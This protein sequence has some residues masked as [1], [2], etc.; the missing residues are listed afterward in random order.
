MSKSM[1]GSELICLA[2]DNCYIC[3]Q[4]CV[5]KLAIKINF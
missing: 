5:I 3:V 4:K 1:C 2:T